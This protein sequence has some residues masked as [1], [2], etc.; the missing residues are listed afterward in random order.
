MGMWTT[1][2][3]DTMKIVL[4]AFGDASHKNYG[5][6]S[7]EAGYLESVIISILPG[8]PKRQQKILI[9]DMVRA[10]QKQEQEVLKKM[11]KD[12]GVDKVS[13]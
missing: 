4:R 12:P 13:I 7:F 11:A 1:D 3:Q 9:E 10:T 8:L 6:H 2:N 5:S